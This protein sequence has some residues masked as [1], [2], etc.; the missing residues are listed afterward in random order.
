MPG[1]AR[2]MSGAWQGFSIYEFQTILSAANYPIQESF[3]VKICPI[4][5]G[6]LKNYGFKNPSLKIEGFENPSLKM[7]KLMGLSELFSCVLNLISEHT[8]IASTQNWPFFKAV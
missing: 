6:A 1:V 7:G 4:F 5:I 3:I 8:Y 2:S